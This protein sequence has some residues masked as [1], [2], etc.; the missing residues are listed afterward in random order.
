MRAIF[1][2]FVLCAVITGAAFSQ[3]A[4]GWPHKNAAGQTVRHVIIMNHLNKAFTLELSGYANRTMNPGDS[5]VLE[6]A[7]GWASARCS[8]TYPGTT[9]MGS[10]SLA[11]WTMG[12]NNNDDWYDVSLVDGYN[13]PVRMFPVKGTFTTSTA[14]YMCD[15]VGCTKD[16]LPNCP[17]ELQVK[18]SDGTL[19]QCLS[20]CAKFHADSFCCSG[21]YSVPQTCHA[22]A[23]SKLFKDACPWAYSYA[24]DDLA[25]LDQCVYSNGIGPDYVIEFGY[26]TAQTAVAWKPSI[27]LSSV[28]A[29]AITKGRDNVL[30]Y[31]IT[32]PH[33]GGASLGLYDCA[34][35]L[36]AQTEVMESAGAMTLAGVSKGVYVAVLKAGKQLLAQSTVAVK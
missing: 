11:E 29:D 28:N 32:G 2:G 19:I 12:S 5:I 1:E 14:A 7:F 6:H 3:D 34:G 22:T 4:T 30:R 20:A 15:T 35:R 26:F 24:Y 9:N 36:V 21:T 8:G 31:S 33:S 18:S 27:I 16:L 23:Y 13:L 17:P 25:S 10:L